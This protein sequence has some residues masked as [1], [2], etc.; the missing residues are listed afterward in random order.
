MMAA[1]GS[2]GP[3]TPSPMSPMS[4]MTSTSSSTT[5]ASRAVPV[6]GSGSI[7]STRG[8]SPMLNDSFIM[9]GVHSG[10]QFNVVLTSEEQALY[11]RSMNSG[12]TGRDNW[13]LFMRANPGML[14]DSGRG[15]PRVLMREFI[16]LLASGCK[17]EFERQAL[18]FSSPKSPPS[19]ASFKGY[20]EALHGVGFHDPE[21][22]KDKVVSKVA[23]FLF[24]DKEALK[25]AL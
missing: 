13:R 21:R 4:S 17:P 23:E 12:L 1:T 18:M 24:A 5:T 16:C 11:D 20:L 22:S 19:E 8:W 6:V 2:V 10:H 7:L 3:M 14:W 25:G 9:G 15:V